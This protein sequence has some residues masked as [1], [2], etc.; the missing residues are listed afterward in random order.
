MSI[1]GLKLKTDTW[2]ERKSSGSYGQMNNDSVVAEDLPECFY[3][4]RFYGALG[5]FV[6]RLTPV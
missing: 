2:Q 6:D 1:Q 3:L 4:K 5:G